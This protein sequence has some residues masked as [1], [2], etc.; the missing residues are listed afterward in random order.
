MRILG[1]GT[2]QLINQSEEAAVYTTIKEMNIC[3]R[4]IYVNPK[5]GYKITEFMEILDVVTVNLKMI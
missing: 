3:N 1:E 4:I 5:N 2:D